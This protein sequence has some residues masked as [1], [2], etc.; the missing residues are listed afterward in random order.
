MRSPS[1]RTFHSTMSLLCWSDE[2]TI[3]V[4]TACVIGTDIQ[5]NVVHVGSCQIH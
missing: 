5:Q 4:I 1:A 3:I 2:T